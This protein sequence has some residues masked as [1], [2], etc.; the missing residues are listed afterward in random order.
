MSLH[1]RRLCLQ[2]PFQ[3][4]VYKPKLTNTQHDLT[5]KSCKQCKLQVQHYLQKVSQ[6]TSNI[7][8]V[9]NRAVVI[10]N[11]TK[12]ENLFAALNFTT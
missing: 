10:H 1:N 12:R 4:L 2:A 5:D 11:L 8:H 3:F 9:Q 7:T 6:E